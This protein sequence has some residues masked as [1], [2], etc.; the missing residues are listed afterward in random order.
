MHGEISGGYAG[1]YDANGRAMRPISFLFM[2]VAVTSGCATDAA[3]EDAPWPCE[4]WEAET[5]GNGT[6][7]MLAWDEHH[8]LILEQ[9]D[10][11]FEDGERTKE[12][13]EKIHTWTYDPTGRVAIEEMLEQ[14]DSLVRW[15]RTAEGGYTTSVMTQDSQDYGGSPIPWTSVE[16]WKYEGTRVVAR[17]L[18]HIRTGKTSRTVVTYPDENTRVETIPEDGE[19]HQRA[20]ISTIVGEPWTM[21]TDDFAGDDSDT[22]T[23][24]E[25]DAEGRVLVEETHWQSGVR[26]VETE[27]GPNGAPKVVRAT[28]SFGTDTTVYS[29]SCD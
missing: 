2:C 11:W 23:T 1:T 3:P 6:H 21:R 17:D 29:N 24:R 10:G 27:R 9:H 13:I 8:N 4:S 25:L 26:R 18:K 22:T 12:P 28:T 5:P 15:R 14:S 20:Q 19:A 16:T 7:K